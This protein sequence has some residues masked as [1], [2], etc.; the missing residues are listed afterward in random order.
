MYSAVSVVIINKT[1]GQ[2]T[3]ITLRK[4]CQYT[5]YWFFCLNLTLFVIYSADFFCHYVI[6][7]KPKSNKFIC[8]QCYCL[9]FP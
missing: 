9:F 3:S 6:R 4:Y 7:K 1:K 8:I 5:I 2:I